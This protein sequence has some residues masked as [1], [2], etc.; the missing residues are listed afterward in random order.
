MTR[1]W[2]SHDQPR[3]LCFMSCKQNPVVKISPLWPQRSPRATPLAASSLHDTEEIL[4]VYRGLKAGVSSIRW[5]TNVRVCV[6][7]L[8]ISPFM[9]LTVTTRFYRVKVICEKF[10]FSP[11]IEAGHLLLRLKKQKREFVLKWKSIIKEVQR[12]ED[13]K[14]HQVDCYT[15]LYQ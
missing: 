14:T 12:A 10:T 11:D 8:I 9:A 2:L 3:F 6:F 13:R 15:T 1:L 4:G 5:G 7:L